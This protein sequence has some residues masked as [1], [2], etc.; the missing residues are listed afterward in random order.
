MMNIHEKSDT[1]A[2]SRCLYRAAEINARRNG[3]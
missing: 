3:E 2:V 1:D